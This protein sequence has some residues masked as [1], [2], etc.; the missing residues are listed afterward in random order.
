MTSEEI[1]ARIRVHS[2][3]LTPLLLALVAAGLL[4]YEELRFSNTQQS[5]L[6]LIPSSPNYMVDHACFNVDPLFM[7][8]ILTAAQKTAETIRTGVP[9][10]EY[11]FSAISGEQLEMGFRA[12]LPIAIRAGRELGEKYDFNIHRNMLDV[13]GGAGGL[14]IA[15]TKAYPHLEATV[16]DLEQVLP[17]TRKIIDEA[18]AMDRVHVRVADVVRDSISGLYD[19]AVVRAFIQ[20]LPPDDVPGALAHVAATIKPSGIIYILGHIL[21]DSKASPIEEVW[22]S[23]L[24]INFYDNPGSYTEAEYREWLLGV[25]FEILERTRLMNGDHVLVGKKV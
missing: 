1:A 8:W 15:L 18:G 23:M 13:G 12:T 16:V 21:D 25:G 17:I 4:T 5:N 6:N 3:K 10:C 9:Q 24:N 22:Y 14:S 19:V 2:G 7:T 20:T 11:D